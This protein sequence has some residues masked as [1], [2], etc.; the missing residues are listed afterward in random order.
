M[1]QADRL[2]SYHHIWRLSWPIILSNMTFPLV[3]AVGVAMM[4]HLPDPAYVGGVG[5]GTLVFNVIYLAFSFLRMGTTGFASQAF[6]RKD[7]AEL[8][9]ILLR[10][11]M[12]A[13]LM[14]LVIILLQ[15]PLI[16]TAS[17]LLQASAETEMLMTRYMA[18]R[19]YDV[20]ASLLNLA[21]LGWLFGQQQMKLCMLHLVFVN[22]LNA[23]LAAF[24]V[25]GMNMTIEGVALASIV[26]QYSGL[27][28]FGV[29]LTTRR[30][31]LSLSGLPSKAR[32]TD[33]AKWR[34]LWQIARDLSLRTLMIWAVEALMLSKAAM[35]GDLSLASIQIVLTMFA[36]IAFGLDGI[37]HATE[38]LVGAFIG[39][40]DPARLKQLVWRSIVMS[41]LLSGIVSIVVLLAQ[42]AILSVMTS[43]PALIESVSA[44]WWWVVL[45]PP[46]SF[47]A[48]L[49]DGVFVGASQGRKM[50]DTT[51]ISAVIC[52]VI[53][54]FGAGWGLDALL[55]GFIVY[56]IARGVLLSLYMNSV[57]AT[58]TPQQQQAG[59]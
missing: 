19:I 43:Q 54:W 36:F 35:M 24:F 25:L 18:I 41:A 50:R 40:Q 46:A 16:A 11:M 47:L 17:H 59:R 3:G 2:I 20:P 6:G 1:Q 33:T 39:R 15:Y 14:G 4:G 37:A 58:A 34:A 7:T 10:S 56:L 53:I 13:G 44:V 9:A 51:I 12:I 28:L 30:A 29:I 27:A 5:L 48:F 57:I 21:I 8:G 49:M 45:I 52:F 32:L 42:P 22:L 31:D 26:A 23:S 55:A 38:A